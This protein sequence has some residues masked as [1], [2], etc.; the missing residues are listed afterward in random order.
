MLAPPGMLLK[1]H[2][3]LTLQ[4]A[5]RRV[6]LSQAKLEARVSKTARRAR[7]PIIPKLFLPCPPLTSSRHPLCHVCKPHRPVCM[8]SAGSG[9]QDYCDP[10]PR[11]LVYNIGELPTEQDA[12][13]ITEAGSTGPKPDLSSICQILPSQVGSHHDLC[14]SIV[15]HNS[16]IQI[17]ACPR[18]LPCQ[19]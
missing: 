11:P 16:L 15:I 2:H 18:P 7:I 19:C 13:L 10:S 3:E 8:Q 12:T 9:C 6:S 17:L 4:P 5:P 1:S 14:D